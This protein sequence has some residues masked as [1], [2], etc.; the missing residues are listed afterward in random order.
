[1][2]AGIARD[3]HLVSH[4]HW[5]AMVWERAMGSTQGQSGKHCRWWALS[6]WLSAQREKQRQQ[7][8]F[9]SKQHITGV[10]AP[11]APGLEGP[12]RWS[13]PFYVPCFSSFYYKKAMPHCLRGICKLQYRDSDTSACLPLA[14]QG[15]TKM[16]SSFNLKT[17]EEME[18]CTFYI[19]LPVCCTDDKVLFRPSVHPW[20]T[21]LHLSLKNGLHVYSER[22]LYP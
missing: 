8:S 9:E 17:N 4:L 12:L 13:P 6:A 21:G 16:L 2:R 5:P 15:R 10:A 19:R 1:M 3:S 14:H 11:V 7:A 22:R 18:I 20:S